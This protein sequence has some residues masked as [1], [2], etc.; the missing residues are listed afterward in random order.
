MNDSPSASVREV[1]CDANLVTNEHNLWTVRSR[2]ASKPS[3]RFPVL[4]LSYALYAFET[5]CGSIRTPADEN[6]H[7]AWS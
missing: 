1:R 4:A 6:S 5:T 7:I 3:G 2:E